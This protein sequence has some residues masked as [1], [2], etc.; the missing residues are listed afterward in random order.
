M[1]LAASTVV[2]KAEA[3]LAAATVVA[4]PVAAEGPEVEVRLVAVAVLLGDWE[5]LAGATAQEGAVTAVAAA[6]EAGAGAAST[7]KAAA[8]VA[9]REVVQRGAV[10]EAAV[11]AAVCTAVAADAAAH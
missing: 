3:V 8:L 11:T 9:A 6:E 4:V 2:L 1:S 10:L 7:G 5:A